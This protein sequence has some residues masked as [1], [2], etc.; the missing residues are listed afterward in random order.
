LLAHATN[1]YKTLFGPYD[2]AGVGIG[3]DFPVIVGL[4]DNEILVK[5][6][7]FK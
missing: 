2:R 1:F 6:F 3:F 4:E 7:T 5:M